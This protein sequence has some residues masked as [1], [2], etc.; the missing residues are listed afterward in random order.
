KPTAFGQIVERSLQFLHILARQPARRRR[1][2]ARG[3]GVLIFETLRSFAAGSPAQR[4]ARR[5]C[6]LGR[7]GLRDCVILLGGLTGRL[8]RARLP[9]ILHEAHALLAQQTLD[10]TDGVALA[11]EEM[12][13]AAQKIEV[14]RAIV[15]APA[16]ALHR[17]DLAEA[18]F[19]EPQHV[20][21]NV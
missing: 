16:A 1:H 5:A 21:R 2:R 18:A 11:I 13:D 10:A 8:W 19:P 14:I 20:L 4:Q 6:A 17:P 15:A 7:L 9:D 3:V 12:A